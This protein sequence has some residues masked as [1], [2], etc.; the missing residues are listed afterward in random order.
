MRDSGAISIHVKDAG[1]APMIGDHGGADHVR[2]GDDQRLAAILVVRADL[3]ADPADEAGQR[4]PPWGAE[5]GSE[6]HVFKALASSRLISAR[7]R[8][9]H[10]P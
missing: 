10:L 1:V 3:G 6:S 8:P 4:L 5:A 9:A 7:L 2:M